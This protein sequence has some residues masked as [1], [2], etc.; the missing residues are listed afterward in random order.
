MHFIQDYK[1]VLCKEVS[2]VY[3]SLQENTVSYKDDAVVLGNVRLLANLVADH[4]P[5]FHLFLHYSLKIHDC[6]S[7]R[8][9][10][11]DLAFLISLSQ[12]LV[13]EARHLG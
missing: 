8:L 9:H 12:V 3:Q 13:D 11:H 5:F 7:S 2:G 6:Q 1:G 4:S 10:T